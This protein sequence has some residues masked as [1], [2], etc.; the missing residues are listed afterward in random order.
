MQFDLELCTK[1]FFKYSNLLIF[2]SSDE[3][4]HRRFSNSILSPPIEGLSTVGSESEPTSGFYLLKKDSQRRT[5]LVQVINSDIQLICDVWIHFINEHPSIQQPVVLTEDHLRTLLYGLRDYLPEQNK[6]HISL[7]I[8]SLKDELEYDAMV[9]SQLQLAL[10][11]FQD[12]VNS[13]LRNHNIKPHWMFA[14]DNLV[15]SAVQAAITIISPELGE[16][17]AA[18]NTPRLSKDLAAEEEGG[19]LSR[20]MTLDTPTTNNT[21]IPSGRFLRPDD[22]T[23]IKLHSEEEEAEVTELKSELKRVKDENKRLLEELLAA[24]KNMQQQLKGQLA[25]KKQMMHV[26]QSQR[27]IASNSSGYV[28]D[29]SSSAIAIPIAPRIILENELNNGLVTSPQ[30]DAPLVAWLN[31]QAFDLETIRKVG[32]ILFLNFGH[33]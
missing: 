8:S 31:E 6:D 10:L 30:E 28:S 3:G 29:G 21:L 33:N 17:L 23:K 1:T 27:S 26:L 32:L 12:A 25:D 2:Y 13:V 7:A 16:N 18:S 22:V 20:P 24:E 9:S 5:T 11:L 19:N 14:L 15:R 4:G